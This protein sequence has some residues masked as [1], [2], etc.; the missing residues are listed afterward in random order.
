MQPKT[1]DDRLAVGGQITPEQVAQL[2][3]QGF[4]AVI[5]N[6]PDGEDPGQPAFAEIEGAARA[7][8]MEARHIPVAGRP[9]EAEAGAFAAALAELPGPVYAYC[10]SGGRSGALAAMA[11]R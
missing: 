8:G 3:A 11:G 10:R 2:K 9:G 1:I 7:Q 6:R 5:C 4:R